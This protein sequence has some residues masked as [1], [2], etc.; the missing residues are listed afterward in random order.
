[1]KIL[2]VIVCLD[3]G[4]AE[5]MLKRLIESQKENPAYEHIVVSLTDI[6]SIGAEIRRLGTQVYSMGMRSGLDSFS[7][8]LRLR[9]LIRKYSPD[10]V[11]TWM[12]HADLLG[13]LAAR[14]AGKKNVVWGIHSTD[15]RAGGSRATILVMKI[16]A[17]VS[18]WVPHTILCVAE[19]SRKVHIAAG[20]FAPRIVVLPNGI[21]M[22]RLVSNKFRRGE[23]RRA[24]G[25]ADSDLVIGT[26]GRFNPVKDYSNFVKA[27]GIIASKYL[28]VRFLM[29]GAQLDQ[30]NVILRDWIDKTGFGDRF[31]LLGQ[32]SDAPDCLAAMDVFCLSSKSEALPTVVI[33][34]MGMG[35]PCVAT[36]VGDTESI[37]G[38]VGIVVPKEDPVAL[39]VGLEKLIQISVEERRALT[40]QGK[41]RV[42][43]NFTIERAR[44]RYEKLYAEIVGGNR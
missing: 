6:G 33:E 39:S 34:A 21:D 16:C 13:G 25:F 17:K 32:R 38:D 8:L 27:A 9:G 26:L 14:L 29:V 42:R 40:C 37:L 11:Q 24:C 35:I 1:M 31:V 44:E 4:G 5:M 36:N 18:R 43:E 15:V 12:Y 10:V 2:H 30:D 19:V 22:S 3:V 28:H 20:Y 7:V 23:I 41:A